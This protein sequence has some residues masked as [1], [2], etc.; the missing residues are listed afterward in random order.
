MGPPTC[1]VV[2]VLFLEPRPEPDAR[3]T[4]AEYVIDQAVRLFQPS[5][6]LA[7]CELI[8]P[9][10]PS[11]E[12]M[13]TQFA[14]YFGRRSAWQTDKEDGFNFYLVENANRWR[15]VPIFS[16]NAAANV[17]SECDMELGVEYS[18]ARYLSAT[19]PL[20][21]LAKWVPDQR[22]SPGHCATLT[23]RVLKNSLRST[24]AAPMHPSAWYGPTT[25]YHEVCATANWRGARMGAATYTGMPAETANHVEQL[26]RG[27]MSPETVNEVGDVGCMEAVRGL[28]MR[29]CNTLGQGDPM[30]QR[31]TQQQLAT[32]LLR[33]VILRG[34]KPA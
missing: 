32:A 24:D 12:G 27:V 28:T 1:D 23:A 25:L 17:R 22:R 5:P 4:T 7:H 34:Q 18:L 6:A 14:T 11:D 16:V 29:V 20:R 21:Y 30:S 13:R 33:W 26:L 15:A 3:W 8:M 31:L 9:P 2:Y 10:I 19:P